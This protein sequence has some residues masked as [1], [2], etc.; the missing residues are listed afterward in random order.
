MGVWL[1]YLVICCLVFLLVIILIEYGCLWI[2]E[3]MWMVVCDKLI[4]FSNL[5]NFL[6]E[7]LLKGIWLLVLLCL[8]V[9]FISIIVGWF[10]LVFGI[11]FIRG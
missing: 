4:F 11:K 1:G 2:I 7:V 3:V 9:L 8:G 5:I 6:F 10:G